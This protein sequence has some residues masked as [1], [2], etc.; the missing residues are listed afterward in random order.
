MHT[1]TDTPSEA[2]ASTAR[3][4]A[5][6]QTLPEPSVVGRLMAV[7]RREPVLFVTLAYVL[8]SFMG[9]WSSY[10]F[11]RGLGLPILDYLQGSDLF[12]AGLRRPDYALLL[13]LPLAILWVSALPLAWAER[14]PVRTEELRARRWWG[15]WL[16]PERRSW[17]GLWGIRTDTLLAISMLGMSMYMLYSRNDALAERIVAGAPHG[18]PVR[19]TLAGASAPLP[20]DAQLLGTT[21]AF[22]LVWW[23]Q[24]GRIEALPTANIARIE[25]APADAPAAAPGVAPV[26]PAAAAPAGEPPS[27]EATP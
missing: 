25:S 1:S 11:Y 12:I 14:N 3:A 27:G 16:F 19:L 15:R 6:M 7:L 26:P 5:A 8:V 17:L 24:P 22:V 4:P 18:Q 10:W 2:E 13:A 9:I 21:S 23:A 20:G